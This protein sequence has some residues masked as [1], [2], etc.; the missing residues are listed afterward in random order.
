[1]SLR[2]TEGA[3][4]RS[5]LWENIVLLEA[6]SAT[7]AQKKA[8]LHGLSEAG[9]DGLTWDDQPAE[10]RFAGVRKILKCEY[11]DE[12]PTDGTEITFSEYIV[13]NEASIAAYVEGRRVTLICDE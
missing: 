6:S 9:R 1:M 8:E 10:F 3:Q 12:R 11:E 7:E 2:L 5:P 4:D 13:E